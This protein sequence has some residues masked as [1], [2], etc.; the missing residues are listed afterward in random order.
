M[1]LE[2][3]GNYP[4]YG[5]AP[6]QAKLA[7]FTRACWY[8]RAGVGWSD[9]PPSP[10]TSATV[11][12][13]LH[14]MLSRAGVPPPYVLV[15]ASI[16]GEYACIYTRRYP[17]DVAGLVFVD[18]SHPDQQEP[19]FML[20]PFNLMSPGKR[21]LICTALPFMAR[22]GILRLIAGRMGGPVPAQSS[23][24]SKILAKLT[25]ETSFAAGIHRMWYPPARLHARVTPYALDRS[26]HIRLPRKQL[27]RRARIIFRAAAISV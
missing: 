15:G 16:G 12:S 19:A 3:G 8:D 5:W 9:P 14:E 25:P 7:N 10:R 23:P 4:R 18:S 2:T 21:R 6:V 1:I 20:S 24:E 26:F 22:F 27:I 17:H 11:I 13:D